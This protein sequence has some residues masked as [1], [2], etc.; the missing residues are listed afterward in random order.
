MSPG[1][2][3]S[4]DALIVSAH[5]WSGSPPSDSA[6]AVVSFLCDAAVTAV[7]KSFTVVK[8]ISCLQN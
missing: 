6:L 3:D 1:R 5:Q 8:L 7:V 2:T 4:H